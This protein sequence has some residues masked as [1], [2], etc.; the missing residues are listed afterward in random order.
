VLHPRGLIALARHRALRAYDA[1]AVP[2]EASARFVRTEAGDDATV[3]FLPNTVDDEFFTQPTLGDRRTARRRLGISE[4][5]KVIVS[6]AQLEPRKGVLELVSGY[7]ALVNEVRAN[8]MLALVGEGSLRCVLDARA[9]SLSHG[10]IRVV[11]HADSL[12]VRNWLWAADAF[13]LATKRDPNPLSVIEAAFSGLPLIMSRQA[14]NTDELVHPGVNGMVLEQNDS[15]TIASVL[16]QVISQPSETLRV[17]GA[18]SHEIAI[19]GFGQS[20]VARQ[21]VDDL[22]LASRITC[23]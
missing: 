18:R 20:R 4:T 1:F 3:L 12:G 15:N 14:G 21:F 13:A 19:H 16:G 17:M 7:E 6:V 22:F 23:L 2:N 11:G 8:S 5:T 9:K 10:E